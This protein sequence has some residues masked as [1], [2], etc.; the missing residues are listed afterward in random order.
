MKKFIKDKLKEAFNM[1]YKNPSNEI[2]GMEDIDWGKLVQ[3]KPYEDILTQVRLD[4]GSE[5]DLYQALLDVY[6]DDKFNHAKFLHI[7]KD[8]D[9]YNQ[10]A[11]FLRMN[12]DLMKKN[13]KTK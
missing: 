12:E 3:T 13:N 1:Q 7:L 6:V 8:Y 4:W 9:V 11:H 5:S 10:Y 2:G